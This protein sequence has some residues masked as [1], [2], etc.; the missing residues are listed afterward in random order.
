MAKLK[1]L[2]HSDIVI[3][4]KNFPIYT[5]LK[6]VNMFALLFK[7]FN[8]QKKLDFILKHIDYQPFKDALNDH[9]YEFFY[10]LIEALPQERY[11]K[12]M[13]I[14]N[15]HKMI[16][17][18]FSSLIDYDITN[19]KTLILKIW[20]SIILLVPEEAAET[21]KAHP[22]SKL[23]EIFTNE[24]YN[25]F[26]FESFENNEEHKSLSEKRVRIDDISSEIMSKKQ[27]IDSENYKKVDYIHINNDIFADTEL[28][29]DMENP[30]DKN[31]V[32]EITSLSG[33]VP[34]HG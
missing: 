9:D 3:I 16:E 19:S 26:L 15:E 27:K 5:K 24:D 34:E 4:E 32:L 18:F 14:Y 28:L 22:E 12:L 11:K 6:F 29:P 23:Q 8:S 1:K 31:T 30:C 25:K 20:N 17:L 7:K 2:S 10:Q 21:V 33:D 13:L